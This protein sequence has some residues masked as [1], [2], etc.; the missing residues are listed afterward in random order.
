MKLKGRVMPSTIF[1]KWAGWLLGLFVAL[2]A[3]FS[4]LV[5]AGQRGG[6]TFFSNLTLT[7]PGLAAAASAIAG[8]ALGALALKHRDRSVVVILAIL[9]GM[10]VL[11]WTTAE[12]VSPH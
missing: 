4:G 1:G 10:L 5:A 2:L 6:E 9:V 8:G 7:I 11:F 12:I 3:L